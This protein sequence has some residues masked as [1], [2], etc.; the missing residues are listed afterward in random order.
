MLSAQEV[1]QFMDD[2]LGGAFL[3]ILGF[4]GLGLIFA[5]GLAESQLEGTTRILAILALIS[6][7]LVICLPI[8]WVLIA[9][10]FSSENSTSEIN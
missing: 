2:F 7:W 9:T 6:G 1:D 8:L 4:L 5:T 10:P 3:F